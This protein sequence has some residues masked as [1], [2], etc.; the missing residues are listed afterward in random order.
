MA[1][2]FPTDEFDMV[3]GL[4]GAHRAKVSVG[5]RLFASLKY[6]VATAVLTVGGVFALNVLSQSA[7][8]TGNIDDGAS[9]TTQVVAETYEGDG[10]GVAV[11]DATG[12]SGRAM[13]VAQ[14]ILDAG[15]NVYGAANAVF[16]EAN[17]TVVYVNN[18]SVKDAAKTLL[19]TIGDYP[20]KVSGVYADPITVI[21][22]KDYK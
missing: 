6:V 19:K 17:Q 18:K 14:Q 15:W 1:K 7:K 2:K 20:I 3:E 16:G 11:V 5:N 13:K 12:K 8:F 9:V 22:G 10:V 21:V 4:G